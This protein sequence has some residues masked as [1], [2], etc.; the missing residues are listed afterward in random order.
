MH[1]AVKIEVH[2]REG[3][4]PLPDPVVIVGDRIFASAFAVLLGWSH[5]APEEWEGVHKCDVYIHFD[6][7]KV[8]QSRYELRQNNNRSLPDYIG[9]FLLFASGEC[10]PHQWT[11]QQYD[12]VLGRNPSLKEE[13]KV[14]KASYLFAD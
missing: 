14:W 3:S 11:Q 9:N 4:H 2:R 13:A 6:D 7:G 10:K 8:Y 1:K 12:M 5:T